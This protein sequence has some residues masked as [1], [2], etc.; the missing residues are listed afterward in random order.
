MTC[1]AVAP[2]SKL[3]PMN[4][5]VVTRLRLTL[6]AI[7]VLLAGCASTPAPRLDEHAWRL[8]AWSVS[9]LPATE[10]EIT[11]RFADGGVSGR[12]A[13]NTYRGP[14]TLGPGNALAFGPMAT[15]K[16]AGPEPAMRAEG[17]YLR[18]LAD[19][20]SYSIDGDRLTLRDA[21]GNE[22]LVFEPLAD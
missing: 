20:A 22:R 9:S 3:D 12:S 13:V 17:I 2:G 11:A 7:L 8:T 14:V 5:S 21:G 6:A 19:A 16:M 15:T 18:L 4:R 1:S 10:F